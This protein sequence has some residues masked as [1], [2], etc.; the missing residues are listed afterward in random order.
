[1]TNVATRVEWQNGKAMC[2]ACFDKWIKQQPNFPYIYRGENGTHGVTHFEALQRYA[3]HKVNVTAAVTDMRNAYKLTVTIEF[4]PLH[5]TSD[6]LKLICVTCNGFESAE[7]L[8]L[9][10]RGAKYFPIY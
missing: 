7:A 8:F 10:T 1:M 5:V 2:K 4:S 9:E 3:R 6:A